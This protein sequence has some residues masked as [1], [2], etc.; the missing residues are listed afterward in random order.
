M[1]VADS[2]NL[3]LNRQQL[4]HRKRIDPSPQTKP[5]LI[6][7]ASLTFEHGSMKLLPKLL[8]CNDYRGPNVDGGG[9][10]SGPPTPGAGACSGTSGCTPTSS[11]R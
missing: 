7:R 5:G 1:N 4:V 8:R 11:I 6:I 2:N 10:S 3:E 9:A